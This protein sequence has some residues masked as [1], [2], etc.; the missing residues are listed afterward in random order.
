M[1]F[2]NGDAPAYYGTDARCPDHEACRAR[3]EARGEDWPL[4]T[5]EKAQRLAAGR[6]R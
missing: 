1:A 6:E 3:V 4:I 5:A 2:D